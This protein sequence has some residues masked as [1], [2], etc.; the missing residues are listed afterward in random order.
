MNNRQIKSLQTKKKISD[1]ALK[2]FNEKSF[3][4]V[5]VD[6]IIS[7]TNTSKGS[8]YTHFKSKHDI[9]LEKFKE[10][11]NYYV[12]ELVDIIGKEK[13]Y[14]NKLTVFL[15]L[16]MAYIERDLGWDVVRT[17]YESE[18]NTNRD[19]LFLL[20]NRPLYSIL[21]KIFDEG[22]KNN[23]FRNDFTPE[24]MVTICVRVMRGILYDWSIHKAD[25]SL[26]EE[27]TDIFEVMIRGLQKE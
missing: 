2:L 7:K 9:F 4:Q 21:C 5:T 25:F 14:I 11:D 12:E 19:S 15:R 10:I 18:L 13:T 23:E 27:Q 6:E 17:I 22:Q 24:Y 20:P 1:I 8:F 16:Q 3:N 26:I